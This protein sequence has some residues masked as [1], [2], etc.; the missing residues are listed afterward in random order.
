MIFTIASIV[1]G[2]ILLIVWIVYNVRESYYSDWWPSLG[3]AV[4]AQFVVMLLFAFVGFI[5]A[6]AYPEEHRT[7]VASYE[8]PLRAIQTGSGVTGSF[9][10]SSGTVEGYRTINY[11]T[12]KTDEDGESYSYIGSVHASSSRIY[13]GDT[14]PRIEVIDTTSF[15]EK[16][17]PWPLSTERTFKFYVPADSVLENY[18]ISNE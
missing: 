13:E 12:T 10:L 2:I 6:E 16:W 15:H 14:S 1:L 11:I 17:F 7:T 8:N 9:F 3:L 18:T 5:V 4:L